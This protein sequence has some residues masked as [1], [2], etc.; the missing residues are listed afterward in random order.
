MEHFLRHLKDRNYQKRTVAIIENGSWAPSAGRGMKSILSEMKD[1]KIVEPL[2][3]IKS[4]MKENDMK[5]L[6][7]LAEELLKNN[8]INLLEIKKN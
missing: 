7:E 2:I 6:E 4:V 5:N 1:I 8:K 3:T